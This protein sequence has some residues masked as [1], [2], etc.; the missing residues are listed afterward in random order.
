VSRSARRRTTF[1][2]REA[3]LEAIVDQVSATERDHFDEVAA[4]VCPTTPAELGAVI[5]GFAR[6]STGVHRALA[7][8]GTRSRSRPGTTPKSG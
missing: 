7:L 1:R 6:D 4:T 3:L 8:S 5:A 2:P